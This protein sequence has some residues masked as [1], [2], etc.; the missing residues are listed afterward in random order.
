M[1]A[2]NIDGYHKRNDNMKRGGIKI[3]PIFR[4]Y[5]EYFCKINYIFDDDFICTIDI[6]D[7]LCNV[8]PYYYDEK[9]FYLYPAF[10]ISFVR[11]PN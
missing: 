3:K 5:W 8:N 9:I 7:Q 2:W 10:W 1:K 11:M 6:R 4:R